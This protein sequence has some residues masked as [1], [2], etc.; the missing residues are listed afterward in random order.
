MFFILLRS[1]AP[2]YCFSRQY[3][4]FVHLLTLFTMVNDCT[5]RCMY[6]CCM[7]TC[8]VCGRL[9]RCERWKCQGVTLMSRAP[10]P[11]QMH[12]KHSGIFDVDG[13]S[14]F[15]VAF[16]VRYI[17]ICY[18]DFRSL[19][20]ALKRCSGTLEDDSRLMHSRETFGETGYIRLYR[21]TE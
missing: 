16:H 8:G 14:L 5:N 9:R 11:S 12:R 4:T 7:C 19:N 1:L 10:N 17:Y 21:Y 3:S 13:W 2:T 15:H 18:I 6:V 20:G